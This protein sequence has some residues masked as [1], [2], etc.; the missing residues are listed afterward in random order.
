MLI[1]NLKV[2]LVCR[3]RNTVV[4]Q[5]NSPHSTHDINPVLGPPTT[6]NQHKTC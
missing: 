2:E 3:N 4:Q 5:L 6:P 1:A